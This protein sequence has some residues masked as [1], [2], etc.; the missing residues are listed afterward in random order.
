MPMKLARSSNPP[1]KEPSEARAR[2]KGGV[3]GGIPPRPSRSE[4]PPSWYQDIKAKQFSI[5][6]KK[7]FGRAGVKKL[8]ENC[9]V[10]LAEFRRAEMRS[11]VIRAIFVQKRFELR[12]V[13]ATMKIKIIYGE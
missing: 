9:F 5:P 2:R 8:K 13:I 4:A 7:K 6:F 10:L 12:S 3:G 11:G 1:K